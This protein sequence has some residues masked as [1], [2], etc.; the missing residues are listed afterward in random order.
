MDL[1]SIEKM[2][3]EVATIVFSD[4]QSLSAN[5]ADENTATAIVRDLSLADQGLRSKNFERFSRALD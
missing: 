2:S 3:K 1:I 4:I 5:D